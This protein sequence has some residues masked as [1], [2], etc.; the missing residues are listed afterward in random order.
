[1][2]F[3]LSEA[4]WQV[5]VGLFFVFYSVCCLIVGFDESCDYL[6]G[7]GIGG[8]FS[9]HYKNHTWFFMH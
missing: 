2:L 4:L 6:L 9:F 8:C 1:M 5:T 7:E 3:I